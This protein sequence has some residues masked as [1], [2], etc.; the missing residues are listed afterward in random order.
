[1]NPKFYSLDNTTPPKIASSWQ[2]SCIISDSIGPSYSVPSVFHGE[3]SPCYYHSV[4]NNTEVTTL[5]EE[6]KEHLFIPYEVM[7]PQKIRLIWGEF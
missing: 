5:E 7:W 2:V 4:E 1:M 3:V 6:K